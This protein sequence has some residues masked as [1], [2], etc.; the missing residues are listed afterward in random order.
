MLPVFWSTYAGNNHV[1]V[2]GPG[3]AQC[4]TE[5][6]EL[7]KRSEPDFK[8]T[9]SAV[10]PVLQADEQHPVYN[11]P[12]VG[13]LPLYAKSYKY[14]YL[15]G[16]APPLPTSTI[17]L[18]LKDNFT[19][20]LYGVTSGHAVLELDGQRHLSINGHNSRIMREKSEGST[21]VVIWRG[22]HFQSCDQTPTKVS[23]VTLLSYKEY[24]P[25]DAK[26]HQKTKNDIALLGVDIEDVK[27][28]LRNNH[29]DGVPLVFRQQAPYKNSDGTPYDI[30]ENAPVAGILD[31][32]FPEDL[33]KL[34][35]KNVLLFL[36]GSITGSI[37]DSLKPVVERTSGLTLGSCPT[38][39][40]SET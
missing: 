5:L 36:N 22:T 26:D 9:I 13:P 17:G 12:L 3:A 24:V 27:K 25:V 37:R 4:H 40:P 23:G 2:Q 39:K 30:D 15:T 14:N 38:F 11:E 31:M 1:L 29:R 8:I 20:K 19:K 6:E 35:T 21:G 7:S 28:W 32:S 18:F 34:Q 16:E 33:E 10:D